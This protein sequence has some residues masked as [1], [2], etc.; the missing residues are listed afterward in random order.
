MANPRE[1]L[2]DTIA[3]LYDNYPRPDELS[4]AR[5]TKMAYLADWK[6]AIE[7]GR[8]ITGL[9][10]EFA[11]YGPYVPDVVRLARNDDDF[12]VEEGRNRYGGRK[13]TISHTGPKEY[14][15]LDEEDREILDFVVETSED[16]SWD[17]FIKLVYSTHPIVTQRRYARLNLVDLA[18]DYERVKPLIGASEAG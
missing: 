11:D 10:W 2:K 8:Q 14:P 12:E 18:T 13:E 9:V 5:L 4:N 17:Q 16:K 6:S 1:I 3:Y 15:T 7:R